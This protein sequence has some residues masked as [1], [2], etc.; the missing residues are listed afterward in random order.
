[1]FFRCGIQYE[2]RYIEG[3]KSPP[4]IALIRGGSMH[5]G[6]SYVNETKRDTGAEPPVDNVQDCVRDAFVER[7]KQQ[8]PLLSDEEAKDKSRVLNDAMSTA[9]DMATTYTRK[10]S[11]RNTNIEV[12]EERMMADIGMA[13]PLLGYTD[14]VADNKILEIKT[15]SKAWSAGQEST[16]VQPTF[17]KI[18]CDKN[19]I[20]VDTSEFIILTKYKSKPRKNV[21]KV[22]AGMENI[23]ESDK[24]ARLVA[25]IQ[26][27]D[28]YLW[29]EET[30]V[31]VDIRRTKRDDE[32]IAVL[33]RRIE[34]MIRMIEAGTFLPAQ[35][36]D[37]CCSEK[38]CGYWNICNMRKH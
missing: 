6:A 21:S 5:S 34:V 29:D 7:V 35:N 20:D 23:T 8:P 38:F 25:Q 18:L 22:L 14:L 2:K 32:D 10:A 30:Q 36:S 27:E 37:W 28:T 24:F 13:L 1:M 31:N 33:K 16:E 19:D 17:Y 9:I 3:R 4:G 11:P 15:S 12:V 26:L